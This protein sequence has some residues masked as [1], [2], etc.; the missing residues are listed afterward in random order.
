MDLIN[1]PDHYSKDKN[2]RYTIIGGIKCFTDEQIKKV[3]QETLRLG[4]KL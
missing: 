3:I 1:S 2:P 4:K